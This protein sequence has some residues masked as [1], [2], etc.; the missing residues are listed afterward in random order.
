MTTKNKFP[1]KIVSSATF[2]LSKWS[3][4]MIHNFLNKMKKNVLKPKGK[5]KNHLTV[6]RKS[7]FGNGNDLADGEESALVLSLRRR[8]K[9]ERHNVFEKRARRPYCDFA[10]DFSNNTELYNVIL[11]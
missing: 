5:I 4:A 7:H 3:M 8:T 9:T 2:K 10:L 1:R 6:D 11:K